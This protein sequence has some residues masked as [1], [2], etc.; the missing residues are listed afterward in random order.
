MHELSV[1]QAIADTARARADGHPVTE[2]AVRIGYLRQIVPDSLRFCWDL[3]TDGS[4]LSGSQL[5]IEHVPAVI[6][7]RGC[8]EETVLEVPLMICG[9]CGGD[10]VTLLSGQEFQLVSLDLAEVS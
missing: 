10:E 6:V 5:A 4:E 3:L 7:C 9:S 2:V 1:A 8:G